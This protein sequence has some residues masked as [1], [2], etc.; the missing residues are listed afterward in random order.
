MELAIA[1]V[2][3]NV[4][5]DRHCLVCATWISAGAVCEACTRRGLNSRQYAELFWEEA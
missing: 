2:R 5:E 3:R 4:V 1:K